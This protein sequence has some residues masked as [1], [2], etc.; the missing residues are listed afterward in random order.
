MPR[1]FLLDGMALVYR[2]H[3]AFIQNPIRNSKGVNTSALY[4]FINTLLTILEKEKP[5]HLGVA[6]DTSA[7]TARHVKYPAYKANRDE[8]P[9]EL[10]AALPGVK[11]FCNAFH[12][13]VIEL[14]G[15]EAD[16]LIG[17]LSLRADAAGYETFMVTPDKDFAQLLSPTCFMWKPGKKGADHE[18]IGM[19]QLPEIWGV[20][21]PHQIIDLLGLMGDSVDNIP[22]VPGIGPKTAQKL[23][24]EYGSI[25]NLLTKTSELKGRQKDNLVTF[26]D[27]ARLS[28]DLATIDRQVPFEL[29]WDALILSQRDDEAVK[30]L[31][32]EFE[33]RTLTKRLFGDSP[34]TSSDVDSTKSDSTPTLFDSY[35]TLADVPHI[36]QLADTSEKQTE[37]FRCLATQSSFCFDIETTSLDRFEARLL[38][39]AFSWNAHE[40]WYLPIH[41]LASQIHPLRIA[42]SS[43]AEKI[44]HNLKYDLSVLHHL[45]I[46]VAGPFYD[47]MLAH[48]LVFPEQRHTMDYLSETMLGYKPIKLAE[49]ANPQSAIA[50]PP[51]DDLFAFAETQKA[52]KDLDIA[53][54]PVA[55]L[56]EYAAED[57]DVTWQLSETIRPMLAGQER[58]LHEIEC[59]LLPVLVRM[60]MEGIAI[61]PAALIEIG[62]QLQIRIDELT[63]S[64]AIHA[65]RPFNLNS[66]KQLGEILFN[67]LGLADKAK[68]TKTGQFKTDEQTLATFAGKHPIIDE[69]LEYREATKLK[70][71]Y[72]DALP[73]HIVK[74]TGRI[75]TQFHQLVAATGRLAS[76]DPNLQNIPV[77]S[78]LGRQIRKAFVP[79]ALNP[80]SAIRDPQ[81]ALL[82]CDYSQIEL[83]IMAALANDASMIEAFRE[84]RDIHTATAAKVWGIA[85]DQVTRDQRSGAKMVNFGIIY[86]ISAF[87][88]SQRLAIPRAEAT[89]I[90]ESYFRQ[91]PAIKEFMAR[92]TLEARECG[93][94]E[95]LTGRRRYFPDLSSGNQNIRGNAER[96]AINTPIQGSA[97]DMIKLAMIRIDSLLQL[98]SSKSKMLLQV[99]DELVF[100]L[101]HEEKETLVPQILDLMQTALPLPHGVP[102]LVEHGIGVNW[103]AAH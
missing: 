35:K 17:T 55:I 82:S 65:G 84:N 40:G 72:L 71:T 70:G 90:I 38:G 21:H 74:E 83:R 63:A 76:S 79:R 13:P 18:I 69:I 97:A 23:I 95:T 77:R 58:V 16:D 75:H 101:A 67:E 25:E 22:G 61:D 46:E 102:I 86:G 39:I 87:G 26:A 29:S 53:A 94:V 44:G 88:L 5:T 2:A 51:S 96:A 43:P 4:G 59:P 9:E 62:G 37:L 49:I 92:T 14:D 103:L 93:Y 30:D 36:Y 24:A 27:Q 48:A 6:F 42:L 15:Y 28:K 89:E 78:V 34:A 64:I 45:G 60:E 7:P 11:R 80:S 20:Q 41:D 33:F 57:A 66:P 99:H 47:T 1:L 100:D 85:E 12:I 10:A 50:K 91:Y 56:G 3:F 52:S 8:M 31:F 98:S 73:G 32:A 68:K 81:F 19:P 54:I